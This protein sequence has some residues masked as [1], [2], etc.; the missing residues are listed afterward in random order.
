MAACTAVLVLELGKEGFAT[1]AQ[2]Q[3]PPMPK[4]T[5]P[6]DVLHS[7]A[8][9]YGPRPSDPTMDVSAHPYYVRSYTYDST[10]PAC[11]TRG[12]ADAS[13]PPMRRRRHRHRPRHPHADALRHDPPAPAHPA[14]A[15]PTAN[16]NTQR[17]SRSITSDFPA[18]QPQLDWGA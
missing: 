18:T 16:S 14:T 6:K 3:P 17:N 4:Y 2:A 5:G 15:L 10:V 9:V 11:T 13:M 8:Y 7:D 12:R 1:S